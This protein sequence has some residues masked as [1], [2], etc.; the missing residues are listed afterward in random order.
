MANDLKIEQHPNLHF[1]G[2]PDAIDARDCGKILK[3]LAGKYSDQLRKNY[4]D[5]LNSGEPE[6]THDLR[7]TTRRLQ[8][9]LDVVSPQP[10]REAQK[11][12]SRIKR[13]RHAIGEERDLAV[14]L[15]SAE[16]CSQRA[17]STS[18]RKLW[19]QIARDMRVE[20][21]SS[22]KQAHRR[23]RQTNARRLKRH[24]QRIVLKSLGQVRVEQFVA[25]FDKAKQKLSS[26]IRAALDSNNSSCYHDV[27]IKTKSLRYTLE[28][29][30]K[31]YS[32]EDNTHTFEFLKSIQDELGAWHD[33]AELCRRATIILSKD[34]DFQADPMA[35][36]LLDSLREQTRSANEHARLVILSLAEALN[37]SESGRDSESPAQKPLSVALP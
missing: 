22:A 18:R 1:D 15:H 19:E 34:A 28:L 26:S 11:L 17:A 12:R 13:L 3:K 5:V 30:S 35:T 37:L 25:A 9:I 6:A 21:D 4:R 23:L 7:V 36:G 16:Q 31:L 20:F 2:L 14:M 33:D 24:V 8:A 10:K 32:R 27:R 29:L